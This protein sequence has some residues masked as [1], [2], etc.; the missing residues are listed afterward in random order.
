MGAAY[1]PSR[2]LYWITDFST[3]QIYS[4][5]PNT[6]LP[7][8]AINVPAGSRLA[9]TGYNAGGDILFYHGRNEAMSYCISASN[10]QLLFSFPIPAGGGNNGQG[11]GCAPGTGNGWLTHYEQPFVYCVE[12]CGGATPVEAST[13]GTI[14]SLYD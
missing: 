6:G 3:S 9:G 12:S 14:K 13:W 4:I 7:G 8:P 11:A 5:N 10:G 2:D 1:D